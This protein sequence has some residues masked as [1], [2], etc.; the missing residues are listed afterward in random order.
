MRKGIITHFL[1]I[2]LNPNPLAEFLAVTTETESVKIPLKLS[3]N[4]VSEGPF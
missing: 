1:P 3:Q 2:P 4:S